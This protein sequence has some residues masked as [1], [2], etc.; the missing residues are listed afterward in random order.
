V[1]EIAVKTRD[2]TASAIQWNGTN[3]AEVITLTGEENA[4]YV[5]ETGILQVFTDLWA[6]IYPG[7]WISK[8]EEGRIGAHSTAAFAWF[9]EPRL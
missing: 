3:V 7:W 2:F 8:D 6:T 9:F 1:P 5:P 4:S